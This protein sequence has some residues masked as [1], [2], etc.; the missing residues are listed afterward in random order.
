MPVQKMTHF[1]RVFSF[2]QCGVYVKPTGNKGYYTISDF[3]LYRVATLANFL[4]QVHLD[5]FHRLSCREVYLRMTT[6]LIGFIALVIVPALVLSLVLTR[7]MRC[8]ADFGIRD[9]SSRFTISPD[10]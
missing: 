6:L 5:G 10:S 1:W 2:R 8:P 7:V 4:H 3:G 9:D